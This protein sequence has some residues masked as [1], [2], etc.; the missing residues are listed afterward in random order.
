MAGG[1]HGKMICLCTGL[2]LIAFGSGGIKPCVSAFMGDQFKPEQVA[3]AAKGLRRVLLGHQLRL[4][5]L[6]PGHSVDQGLITAT[7]AAFAR[8]GN[9]D[10]HRH[11][12]LL[13][14]D[15]TLCPRADE[16][17]VASRRVFHRVLEAFRAGPQFRFAALLNIC[18]DHRPA[19]AGDDIDERARFLLIA[20]TGALPLQNSFGW[21]AL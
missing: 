14:G 1:V 6:V 17:R 21:T 12:H 7:A 5:L 19:G 20:T 4:V 3:S 9:F 10:G 15:K 11:V 13:A 16:P 8:A 18:R 2:G